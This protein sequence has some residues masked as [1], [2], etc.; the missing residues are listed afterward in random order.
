MHGGGVTNSRRKGARGE[1][2]LAHKVEG[3]GFGPAHRGQQHDG[4]EGQDVKTSIPD[5]H[6]ES[7]RGR[8]IPK[9]V[10]TAYEQAAEDARPG[11]VPVVGLRSDRKPWLVLVALDDLPDFARRC[12][13]ALQRADGERGEE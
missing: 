8:M 12:A 13:T 10:Y 3:L 9:W 7:K 2:E 1:V 4:T 11:A 6:W 5:T